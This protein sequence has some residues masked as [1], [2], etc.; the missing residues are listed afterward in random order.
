MET[1]IPTP[2]QEFIVNSLQLSVR[3]DLKGYCDVTISDLKSNSQIEKTGLSPASYSRLLDFVSV[4]SHSHVLD[5]V[6]MQFQNN[7]SSI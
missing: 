7:R 1:S 6:A 2:A 4:H 5:M 3:V